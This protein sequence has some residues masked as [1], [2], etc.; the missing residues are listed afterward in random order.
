MT[1]FSLICDVLNLKTGACAWVEKLVDWSRK[2]NY[3][4]TIK[5]KT[6][7]TW[8]SHV[9][10]KVRVT[11]GLGSCFKDRHL[12]Y[13]I[14]HRE[15][16]SSVN[17]N[18]FWGSSTPGISQDI[19]LFLLKIHSFNLRLTHSQLSIGPMKGRK[20][21]QFPCISQGKN[22]S[23]WHF[24]CFNL[25]YAE[26]AAHVFS[27][28]SPILQHSCK[29]SGEQGHPD[30][31]ESY[32]TQIMASMKQLQRDPLTT[33]SEIIRPQRRQNSCPQKVTSNWYATDL[34]FNC[35][36]STH[37]A[38]GT[39]SVVSP[40][41]PSS[42]SKNQKHAI[43]WLDKISWSKILKMLYL[44]RGSSWFH[45]PPD[46]VVAEDRMIHEEVLHFLFGDFWFHGLEDFARNWPNLDVKKKPRCVYLS[47]AGR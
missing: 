23:S 17:C 32:L 13:F 5:T 46:L 8:S 18:D 16:F 41:E 43:R 15:C 4:K 6:T 1:R 44:P 31:Q 33:P 36:T 47:G 9:F 10:A 11:S 24:N 40:I 19:S 20:V 28:L 38:F 12:Q 14:W 42:P 30:I 35:K 45:T 25:Q 29:D 26:L 2:G 21:S 39:S 22:A 34:S 37:E 3:Q 7:T 27:K